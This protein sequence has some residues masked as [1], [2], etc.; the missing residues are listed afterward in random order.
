MGAYT[1]ESLNLTSEFAA[2]MVL[3]VLSG[4]K[5]LSTIV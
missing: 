2:K 4:K 3:E 1:E 5:P